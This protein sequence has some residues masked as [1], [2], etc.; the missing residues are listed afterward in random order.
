MSAELVGWRRLA[1]YFHQREADIYPLLPSL[2]FIHDA[3]HWGMAF[4]RSLFEIGAQDFATI[5]AAMGV[6]LLGPKQ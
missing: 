1:R 4:R 3:S 5:A 2:L 6:D